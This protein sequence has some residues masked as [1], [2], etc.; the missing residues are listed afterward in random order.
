MTVE[1]KID[2]ALDWQRSGATQ[3]NALIASKQEWYDENVTGFIADWY[4][5]VFNLDTATD[6]GLAVWAAILDE[7]LFGILEEP[8]EDYPAFGFGSSFSNFGRGNFGRSSQT[9]YEFTTEQKRI[10]LKLKAYILHMSGSVADINAGLAAIFGPGKVWAINNLDET[11]TYVLADTALKT[12]IVILRSKDL[13]PRPS[14]VRIDEILIENTKTW[15]FGSDN[16]NFGRGNFY[17][18]SL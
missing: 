12:F 13:L 4:N 17:N 14:T 18:G 6:F 11:M 8:D 15:G 10:V 5:D 16:Y 1:I 3:L 9:V 7:E 2:R